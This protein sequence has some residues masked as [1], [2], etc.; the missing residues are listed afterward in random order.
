V[1]G[2]G[3]KPALIRHN[4]DAIIGSPYILESVKSEA[5]LALGSARDFNPQF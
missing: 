5:C 2:I 3:K 4:I 1:F